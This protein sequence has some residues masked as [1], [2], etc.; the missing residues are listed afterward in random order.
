MKRLKILCL[1]VVAVLALGLTA[2]AS[3]SAHEFEASKSGKLK[4]VSNTTQIFTA[5]S[6]HAVECSTD[7]IAKGEAK[8]GK[9]ESVLVE[10]EY[11]GCHVVVFG[12]SFNA[13]VSLA[14]YLFLASGLVHLENLVKISVPIA[15]C[16]IS[17]PAQNNLESVTY[18]NTPAKDITLDANVTGIVST[19]S[20]GECGSGLSSTG[21]YTGQTVTSLEGGEIKWK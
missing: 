7:E 4:R 19:G 12:F 6:S 2:A 20:G 13:T 3:A 18:L 14:Q 5:S 1:A 9:Q 11:S 16:E 17:V 8:E 15:G 10:V 21:T